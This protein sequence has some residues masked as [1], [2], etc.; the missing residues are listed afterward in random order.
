[1]TTDWIGL[2]PP[3]GTPDKILSVRSGRHGNL[4]FLEAVEF[5]CTRCHQAYWRRVDWKV[6]HG[7]AFYVYAEDRHICS[8]QD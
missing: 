7:E 8:W 3:S 6:L 1:M 5:Q 2:L 4:A